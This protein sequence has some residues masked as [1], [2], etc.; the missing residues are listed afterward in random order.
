LEHEENEL[1]I[2][3]ERE[4][5]YEDQLDKNRQKVEELALLMREYAD[6]KARAE[7]DLKTK[8][9]ELAELENELAALRLKWA[10]TKQAHLLLKLKKVNRRS[11]K[12]VTAER[13]P[14]QRLKN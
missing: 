14:H 7:Q 11:T 12:P 9:A 8:S 4:S 13:R 5:R 1:K 10:A 3:L 2:I 6:Q